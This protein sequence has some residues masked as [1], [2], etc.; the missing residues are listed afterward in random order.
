M[1]KNDQKSIETGLEIAII[2]MSGKFPGAGNLARFWENL[3]S[4]TE[5]ITFFSRDELIARGI[6]ETLLNNPDYVSASG[7][8]SGK[9]NFDSAFF[10]FSPKEAE[11]TDPQIRLFLECSWET[12]EDAGYD[13]T[14]YKGAIGLYAGIADGFSWRAARML[15]E[16]RTGA[17]QTFHL[18]DT[19]LLLSTRVSHKLDLKGPSITLYTACSTS[20]VA[21]HQACR[22]LLTGECDMALA[23]A[24]SAQ[25]IDNTGYLYQEGMILSPDGHN[26]SFDV[27]AKGTIF[28][29][30]IG[31][32]LLKRLKDAVAAGDNI[33]CV[34]KASAINNDGTGKSSYTAPGKKRI[35]DVIRTALKLS[36]LAPENINYVETHG[37]AT[38]L[39]DAIEMEALKDAFNSTQKAY[40]AV[41]SVKSNIGHLD[42]AA[43]MAGL[44]KT[45]QTIQNRLIPPSLHFETPNPKIDFIDSPFYVN[46]FLTPWTDRQ[47][48]QDEKICRAGICS[49]GI[50]GTNVFLILEE[51]P[52]R[53]EFP[54]S[55]AIPQLLIIS[56]RTDSALQVMARNL[57]GYLENNPTL[58][59]AD[60]AYTLQVGRKTF[61]RRRMIISTGINEAI[62]AL[63]GSPGS[64]PGEN[65]PLRELLAQVGA[66]WLANG[67]LDWTSFY[68]QHHE[69]NQQKRR[70][71]SLPTYPFEWQR[72]WIDGIDGDPLT[73]FSSFSQNRGQ[74]NLYQKKDQANKEID[75]K[76]GQAN[77]E[78]EKTIENEA[79]V[80]YQRPPLSTIYEPP[81]NEIEHA[82]A[83]IWQRFFGIREIGTGDDFFEL[84][85]DSLKVITVV[86]EIHKQMN[87]R[88]PIPQVFDTPTIKG[89]ANYI[90]TMSTG[91][92]K[93][94]E[95]E[96]VEEKEYYPL[97]SV[98]MRIYILQQLE[99]DSTGYNTPLLFIL[100]GQVDRK[101]MENVF[102]MLV[103]RHESLRTSF[104]L[105]DGEVVQRI[106]KEV[107]FE[108]EY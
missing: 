18:L 58:N 104:E 83:G 53:A 64:F 6:S 51:F 56:A 82:L 45:I 69:Y 27:Q 55:T 93:Y 19:S 36:R 24:V 40:C 62:T 59:L 11:S 3:I 16:L 28:G 84:G 67:T 99:V 95:I 50:G 39:G 77:L 73:F 66:E 12:L 65:S 29:E 38:D 74:A 22:A 72:Y 57:A 78:N 21:V 100:S 43:G 96:P 91:G 46:T 47:N 87:A 60:V 85:G 30:G 41:G 61:N 5:T 89:L 2:G 68:A 33:K 4:G 70:R 26:R 101:R 75:Q 8:L 10:G 105:I 108:I 97:S 98:Q 1:I 94:I 32:V 7:V 49:F 54:L 92:D 44:I 102:R 76:R 48:E 81:G 13:S 35:A 63:D 37:T 9:E 103:V 106:H 17:E 42:V 90:K 14:S 86:T 34:I 15:K 31:I 79:Q 71:I 80:L 107:D 25:P 20:L 23:G 52:A 88:V